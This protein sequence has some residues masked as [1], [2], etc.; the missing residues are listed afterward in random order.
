MTPLE[1]YEQDLKLPEFSADPAQRQAVEHTQALY[2][3]LEKAVQKRTTFIQKLQAYLGRNSP[4]PVKGIYFWGGV[5]RGKTYIVDTFYDCLTFPQKRRIHFH[6]FMQMVHQELKQ[7]KNV[8]DPLKLVADKFSKDTRVLCFDEF[9]VSDI[10]DAMLLA[11]LL[12]A[13]FERGVTLVATSNE[14]PDKLY[15]DG[16]QRERFLPAIGLLK[17][18][19]QVVNV[20]SGVDYRLRYLDKAQIYR[21]PLNEQADEML[22]EHFHHIASEEGRVNST[23]EIEGRKI[24]V[25]RF[26]DGIVWFDFYAICD[27][28]RGPADYIEIGRQYQTV[29]VANVP[30]FQESE[31]DLAK[32]F[33]TMVDEFY[34]RNVKLIITAAVKPEE[35]YKGKRLEKPFRRTVSR[36][37][38][39]QTHDYLGKQHR[40]D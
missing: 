17:T 36:L 25:A 20:D 19:T 9:H 29:L 24:R 38:E 10:T 32:R 39:M 23:I 22:L 31:N 37:I 11:G 13:L 15:W 18:Y 5:G 8:E 6:R 12:K 34:D 7:L 1:R 27:G 16:L 35:L 4:Q 3:K 14:H 28:P 40:C 33:M 21:Y 30:Q 2:D 26:V